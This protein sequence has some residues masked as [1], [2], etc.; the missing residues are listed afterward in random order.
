MPVTVKLPGGLEALTIS[1]TR[2]ECDNNLHCF[3]KTRKMS[4]DKVGSC[5]SCGAHLVDWDRVRKRDLSDADFT[6]ESL[7][8]E[9]IRHH[10]WHAPVDEKAERHAR[11]KGKNAL[12]AAVDKRLHSSVGAAQPFR[13]GQQT[14]WEGNVIYY[15]QHALACC[16]RTCIEY[17]HGIPKGTE[18]SPEQLDYFAKLVKLFIEERMPN[19]QAEAERIPRRDQAARERRGR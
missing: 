12:W 4:R 10:F 11:R 13:D 1:C 9:W 16:C 5:R 14:P 3:R 18:L 6:F 17:W 19:L 7:K 8:R 15:A 2:S